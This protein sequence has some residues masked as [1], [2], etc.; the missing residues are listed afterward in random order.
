MLSDESF[1]DGVREV[2]EEIGI[3]V[4]ISELIPLGVMKYEAAHGRFIDKEFAH[5]FVHTYT[6]SL[7]DFSLQADEVAGIF[8]MRLRDFIELWTENADRFHASGFIVDRDG[9]RNEVTKAVARTDFVPHPKTFYQSLVDSIRRL[10]ENNPR[11][12]S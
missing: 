12:L 10:L 2:K 7:D 9:H 6:G 1:E 4:L 5:V 8:R 3:E 11:S